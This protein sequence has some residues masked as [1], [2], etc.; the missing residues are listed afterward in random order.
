[1]GQLN[2]DMRLHDLF[3]SEPSFS[4]LTSL[5]IDSGF[6]DELVAAMGQAFQ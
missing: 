2:A 6:E 1:M 4:Y 5:L 3:P